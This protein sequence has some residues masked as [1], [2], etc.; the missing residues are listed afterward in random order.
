MAPPPPAGALPPPNPYGV[1]P[2]LKKLYLMNTQS[3]DAGCAALAAAL[4]SGTLPALRKLKLK[5][6]PVSAS[7]MADVYEALALAKSR[8]RAARAVPRALLVLSRC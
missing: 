1:L 8:R 7:S 6:S 5:G 2:T 4:D 3:T